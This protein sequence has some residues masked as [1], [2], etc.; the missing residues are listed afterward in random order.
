MSL[1]DPDDEDETQGT[2]SP[3]AEPTDSV[4]AQEVPEPTEAGSTPLPPAGAQDSSGEYLSAPEGSLPT[5][6]Q[7]PY[8]ESLSPVAAPVEAISNGAPVDDNDWLKPI[9]VPA[10]VK[11]LPYKDSTANLDALKAQY[12]KESGENTKPSGW[13]RF[14][15]GLAGG[16]VAYGSRNAGEG[17]AVADRI[18]NAPRAA[19]E[20]RW[21]REE[22]PLAQQLASDQAENATIQRQNT[23]AQQQGQEADRQY[24]N[25]ANA[26]WRQGQAQNFAAQAAARRNTPVAFTPDDPKNPYAGGTVQTA[27][28]RILKGQAPPEKWIANWEKN[29]A[30]K[31]LADSQRGLQTLQ[32]LEA[33]GVKL[34]QEQR[35]IVASGGKVTPSVRTTISIRENPDGTPITPK[36]QAMT[37]AQKTTIINQRDIAM[38]LAANL[39]DDASKLSALQAAQDGY[40]QKL[41]MDPET[42]SGH[43]TIN[44]DFTWSVGGQKLAP[45]ASP[46]GPAAP[47]QQQQRPAAQQQ[48]AQPQPFQWKGKTITPGQKA[49]VN[50]QPVIITGVNPKTGKLI[51][52]PAGGGSG[53]P[54][55][56]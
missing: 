31:A 7:G 2:R 25:Q 35:A 34:T 40:E 48:T 29:P 3:F 33:S 5:A 50:G 8:G 14:A 27:D 17:M 4:P 24:R 26:Q 37:Q 13:R 45:Q 47:A 9:P 1:F 42:D 12:A 56:Q 32:A 28:G 38:R 53:P 54:N 11:Y 49:N 51:S 10:A 43:R 20:E 6:E 19:A 52:Q 18:N 55:P 22:R 16:A 23:V 36:S 21:Q 46:A 41:G 15:A 44:P 30:N 39:P